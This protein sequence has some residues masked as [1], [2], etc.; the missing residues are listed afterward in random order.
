MYRLSNYIHSFK[1]Y[2][3]VISITIGVSCAII[4]TF[5]YD[6]LGEDSF[7]RL[8]SLSFTFYA[9]SLFITTY[10]YFKHTTITKTLIVFVLLC[11]ISN[12]VDEFIYDATKVEFNDITRLTT[13]IL[14]T[15]ACN[16]Y[17]KN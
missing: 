13:I 17:F 15:L 14:I 11:T 4:S 8:Q 6:L 10:R 3:F 12:S 7:F 5:F 1:K 16:R 9:I 2:L